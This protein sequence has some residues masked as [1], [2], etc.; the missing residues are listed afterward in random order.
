MYFSDDLSSRMIFDKVSSSYLQA[1]PSYPAKIYQDIAT[2]IFK[3]NSVE[4]SKKILEIGPGS[5]QAT[6]ALEVW[7]QLL[8]CI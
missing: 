4:K 3:G 7:S 2:K 6:Q 1:R 8:V 5:G